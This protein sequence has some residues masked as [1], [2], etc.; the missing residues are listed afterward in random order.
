[1][2]GFPANVSNK[3]M[4]GR[5]VATE[6]TVP[7]AYFDMLR[8]DGHHNPPAFIHAMRAMFRDVDLAGRRVLEIGSGRGLLALWAGLHGAAQVVSMEPELVGASSGVIAVQRQRIE[9]LGTRNVVV[10][11][12]DFNTWNPDGATFDVILSRASINHLHQS[13]RHALKDPATYAGYVEVVRKIRSMLAP[14]GVF[15]ATDACRYALFTAL[16][17]FGIRRPWRWQRTG[18]NW[19]H[20]QNPPTWRRI[21]KDAGFRHVAVHYPVPYRLRGLTAVIDNPAANFLID[22]GFIMHAS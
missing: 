6:A 21:F 11:P 14:G 13:D 12:A 15:I 20:H 17:D 9:T 1:M 8:A 16:R 10:V 19:R 7:P 18:I 3:A 22:G 4:N 2:S 5:F